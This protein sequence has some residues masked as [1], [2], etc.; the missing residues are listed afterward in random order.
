MSPDTAY[1][2]ERPYLK[3]LP[4]VLPPIYQV[5]QRIIDT[6]G[7]A[8][9]DSNRYSVPER[10]IGCEVNVYKYLK[11]IEIYFKS[12]IIAT[13]E[14]I[15]GKK[16]QRVI[17]KG[18]HNQITR[19][20]HQKACNEAEQQLVDCSPIVAKYIKKLKSRVRG[21]GFWQFRKLLNLKRTY[22]TKAFIAAIERADKYDL[23]D[24]KRVENLIIKYASD[25]F[26][27]L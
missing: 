27:N 12:K 17:I 7:F 3:A 13:H 19:H 25:N 20:K 5:C 23:Y 10:L 1:I 24:I 16:N 21:R 2:Q 9:L 26:F 11:K 15:I 4:K 18:H 8:S 22:S 6:Q 14:R